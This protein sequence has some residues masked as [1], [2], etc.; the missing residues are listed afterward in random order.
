MKKNRYS[1]IWDD[2]LW[3]SARQRLSKKTNEPEE[4]R[5]ETQFSDSGT[6]R[7]DTTEMPDN[8]FDTGIRAAETP[9]KGA[10][11]RTVGVAAGNIPVPDMEERTENRTGPATFSGERRRTASSGSTERFVDP[12]VAEPIFGGRTS[13]TSARDFSAADPWEFPGSATAE[14]F[15]PADPTTHTGDRDFTGRSSIRNGSPLERVEADGNERTER[16][17]IE[18]IVDERLSSLRVYVLESDITEAQNS[19]KTMVDRASY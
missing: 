13:V 11:G 16:M 8:G 7:A 4:N 17:A 19:V 14:E 12:E 6:A 2:P 15:R 1:I 9:D 18:R 5:N 10:V 3:M